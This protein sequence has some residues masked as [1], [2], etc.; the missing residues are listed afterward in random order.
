MRIIFTLIF[1]SMVKATFC[2]TP[3]FI[4][5]MTEI[6]LMQG[7]SAGVAQLKQILQSHLSS[8][9]NYQL[10]DRWST[11]DYEDKGHMIDGCSYSEKS[12]MKISRVSQKKKS[13]TIEKTTFYQT[14]QE[15]ALGHSCETEMLVKKTE[16]MILPRSPYT[17]EGIISYFSKK[18]FIGLDVDIPD[19][20]TVMFTVN[21][22]YGQTKSY[23]I[24]LTRSLFAQGFT[25]DSHL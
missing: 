15:S 23:Q 20:N 4:E 21:L 22:G 6:E 13:I 24:D 25:F 3:T 16:E 19:Q 8:L 11:P 12:E 10:N 2:L 7:K 9:Q 17:V 1:L 14:Q 18:E 5:K